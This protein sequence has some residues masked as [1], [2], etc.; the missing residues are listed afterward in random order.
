MIAQA[1]GADLF[2]IRTV[3]QYPDTYDAAIDQ[4]LEEQGENFRPR[5]ASHVENLEDYSV[6]FLVYPNWW[7]DL[8]MAVYSFLDEADLTGKTVI[9]VVTSGSSGFSGTVGAV[10]E[11]EPGATVQQGLS[12][13]ASS[14]AGA[15]SQ[16]EEW[17]AGLGYM[18]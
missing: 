17:L 8:P 2:S 13:G 14:T 7:G 12:I 10:E 1:S 3:E 15:Q 11:L 18:G 9:P 16:V 6:V 5:L 4:G